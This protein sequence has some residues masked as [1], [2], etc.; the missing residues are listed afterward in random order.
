MISGFEWTFLFSLCA[1]VF[2]KLTLL[3]VFPLLYFS[4]CVF[5]ELRI[6]SRPFHRIM[7]LKIVHEKTNLRWALLR[8]LLRIIFPFVALGLFRVSVLDLLSQCRWEKVDPVGIKR[9]KFKIHKT[10]NDFLER[11]IV[12]RKV[13]DR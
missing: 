7:G 11:R 6:K 3:I 2:D 9:L 12:L 10:I 5:W 1:K 13:S 8:G 4:W